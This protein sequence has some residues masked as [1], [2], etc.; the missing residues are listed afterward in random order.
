LNSFIALK[1]LVNDFVEMFLG[2]LVRSDADA[3]PAA[4]PAM[5]ADNIRETPPSTAVLLLNRTLISFVRLTRGAKPGSPPQNPLYEV[6]LD[7]FQ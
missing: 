7:V 1:L 2:P 5:V 4:A 3:P 6:T